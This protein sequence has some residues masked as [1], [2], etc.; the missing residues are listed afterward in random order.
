MLLNWIDTHTI[1]YFFNLKLEQNNNLTLF[2]KLILLDLSEMFFDIVD[3]FA[4]KFKSGLKTKTTDTINDRLAKLNQRSL[5]SMEE[6]ST[7]DAEDNSNEMSL[8]NLLSFKDK[9]GNTPMLF[10][11]FR[12]NIKVM[13]K[14]IELGV[15]YD[16]VNNAGLNII[17]MA[18]QSD[19]ANVIVYFKEKYNF[20][21]FQNDDLN[22]NSL[23]WACSSGSKSALDY[24]LLYINKENQ[25]EHIINCVNSQGQTALHI[26]ILTTGSV[27][28]IKK[29]IKKNININ[30]KDNSGLTVND[31]V[32][33]NDRFKNIEKII[34]EYTHKNCLGLN[35][36]INDKKNQ[37]IKFIMF[38]CLT[39]FILFS[40]VFLFLPFLRNQQYYM[41][42][43]DYVFFFSTAVFLS[44]Y[45][46]I[47][48]SDPG[49]LVK[50]NNDN[51]IQ[52]ISSG[53]NINKMCPYCMVDQ[54]KF[55]KHCFLCNKCIE[56]FDHHCHWI[57]NCVGHLNKP[58]FIG[59]IISL[60]ITLCIDSSICIYI[61]VMQSNA[62]GNKYY[63]DNI[64]FRVIY[65][66]VV[67]IFALFF[68]FPVS[69]LLYMQFKN[70]DSQKEVQTY[71]KEVRELTENKNLIEN[72]KTEKL[73]P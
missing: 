53:K 48:F 35:Y 13:E 45:F 1:K 11:A 22:N 14:M 43:I 5:I 18:A 7:Y 26:T 10:A 29:L 47:I 30:I 21:L 58:Y 57:N 50:N 32:K 34:F 70:K 54:G 46:Y 12:G 9:G 24:L 64:Y 40:I 19:C 68:V 4:E 59:F 8:V 6:K 71:Y 17:H 51:W 52:I 49:L 27:S 72:D 15:K 56:I 38:I 41:P 2:H 37:Y 20:D 28:T 36:H 44:F 66:S 23:H 65:C 63:M 69:Y 73:L 55:S 42:I 67:L 3:K 62:H 39:I 33:D 61:L 31:I 16:C 60:L 25:N